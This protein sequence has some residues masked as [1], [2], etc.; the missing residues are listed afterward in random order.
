M[1]IKITEEQKKKLF[2]PRKID[3]R[4]ENLVNDMIT[5]DYN[6]G[7]YLTRR[8][9]YKDLKKEINQIVLKLPKDKLM[10]FVKANPFWIDSKDK[11]DFL[12]EKL[13]F[14]ENK[15]IVKNHIGITL[16]GGENKFFTTKELKY[17]EDKINI[18]SKNN[19]NK[20]VYVFVGG[21][22]FKKV[23]KNNYKKVLDIERLIKISVDKWNDTS[24]YNYG[25]MLKMMGIRSQSN[26]KTLY[27]IITNKGLL[28]K[29]N[30]KTGSEI[31]DEILQAIDMKKER[32]R[33]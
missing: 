5:T 27:K 13:N 3:E 29:Y 8:D 18:G 2:I 12:F 28:S 19:K 20:D 22:N 6:I 33:Y 16:A 9:I 32:L 11:I 1:K 14:K 10:L 15:D 30:G 7:S 31:P 23:G 26:N 21:E 24:D 4:Y 25:G 17:Y